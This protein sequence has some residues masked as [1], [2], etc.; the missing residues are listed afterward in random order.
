MLV[1]KVETLVDQFDKERWSFSTELTMR[2]TFS[3]QVRLRY[4]ASVRVKEVFECG[5]C[6]SY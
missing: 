2:K 3:E 6:N 1:L 5:M 4:R